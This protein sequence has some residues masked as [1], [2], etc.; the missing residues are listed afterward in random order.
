MSLSKERLRF[1]EADRNLDAIF[2]ELGVEGRVAIFDH[3]AII[4]AT[5]YELRKYFLKY[6][7]AT[8][9]MKSAT[10]YTE[11]NQYALA[12]YT[13]ISYIVNW[14]LRNAAQYNHRVNFTKLLHTQ[15]W[16]RCVQRS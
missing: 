15:D 10:S 2:A 13:A 12:R 8:A 16:K 9:A 1:N 3:L 11:R 14:R 7:R 6:L 5:R 4:P